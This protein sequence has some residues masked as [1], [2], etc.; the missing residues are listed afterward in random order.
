MNWL[1]MAMAVK[2]CLR[3]GG[4]TASVIEDVEFSIDICN[5]F[6][7]EYITTKLTTY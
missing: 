7:E 6:M 5:S 2:R 3:L 4:H 1:K